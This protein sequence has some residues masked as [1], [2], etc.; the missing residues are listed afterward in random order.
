MASATAVLNQNPRLATLVDSGFSLRRDA[1]VG[2]RQFR[3]F[4]NYAEFPIPCLSNRIQSVRSMKR[5]VEPKVW[6]TVGKS[7]G[8]ASIRLAGPRTKLRSSFSMRKFYGLLSYL[9]IGVSLLEISWA[10]PTDFL[11]AKDGFGPIYM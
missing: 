4:A 7:S 2:G 6:A 11:L 1:P 8:Y 3:P 9:A 10:S 5:G